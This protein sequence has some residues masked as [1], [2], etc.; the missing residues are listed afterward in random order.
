[1][2]TRLVAQRYKLDEELGRG[3]MAVVYRALDTRLNRNVALKLLHPYL[4]T[5]PE[6]AA[7][8][9]RESEA[10]AK[11][12]HPNI[13]EIFDAGT[14]EES[15]SHFLVM[16]LVEGPTLS[17]FIQEH[18]TKIPEV[19]LA[20]CCCL[21]DAIEHAHKAGIIHRDIKP[22]NIMISSD[23]VMKLMDFGIA[24]VLDADRM[25]AS[26]S[27]VG[28]PAHMPPEIIEGQQYTFT[29][30][31]FS[32]GTVLYYVLTNTLPYQGTTPM[33]VFKAILDN[34]YLKPSRV[35]LAISK[36]LDKIV[37]QCLQTDPLTRYQSAH[38]LRE[39]ILPVLS[40]IGFGNYNE[41]LTQYFANP[42]EFN[43]TKIPEVRKSFNA[44]AKAAVKSHHTPLALEY[45]N[46]ILAYDPDDSDACALLEKL[47]TGDKMRRITQIGGIILL[48]GILVGSIWG[49]YRMTGNASQPE[50]NS[51][52][53]V[54]IPEDPA[55]SDISEPTVT[56][57]PVETAP[58][59]VAAQS[60][61]IVTP[62]PTVDENPT[63]IQDSKPTESQ[64]AEKTAVKPQNPKKNTVSK[65]SRKNTG[66]DAAESNTPEVTETEQDTIEAKQDT[67]IAEATPKTL[68]VVQP[69]FP[70]DAYAVINGHRYESNAS[71][72]I[73]M[74]LP[75]GKYKMVLGCAKRCVQHTETITVDENSAKNQ[76]E[77]ISL[78]WA[79]ATLV[80][81]D[82]DGQKVFYVARR[83][84]DRSNR[85]FHLVARQP[86][87]V[88]GFNA[89]GKAIQLEVYAIPTSITLK[90]YDT[91]ALEQAK[92]AS[93]RV[94]LEPGESRTV[95]F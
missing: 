10:I 84:D 34:A 45:L 60:Q 18:P 77:V 40:D 26:G 48:L 29:C 83:L 65:D 27:L 12:H 61:P 13:V 93:T 46:C 81:S 88:S 91:N 38:E 16:E 28:S 9:L 90:S 3:G 15:K 76:R 86:N 92:Y 62:E 73:V 89:F 94:S 30:D 78:D 25:T 36:T 35:S 47:R 80:L 11:L 54:I 82:P 50:N 22:E 58:I 37:S 71:G 31:I 20:M 5:Q 49:F 64:S 53:T 1:M 24:R 68:S 51:Q 42:E 75:P 43:E 67:A 87:A 21:C 7:R 63:Q 17:T 55:P 8:F 52:F 79:D 56:Q 72:D 2:Q 44:L 19:G 14:D 59:V 85:V 95:R 6:N 33:T 69:V 23:G 70:P 41:I 39:A 4:A 32:L 74:D 57:N 66:D